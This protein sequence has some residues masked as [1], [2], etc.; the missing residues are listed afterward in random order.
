MAC[1][2]VSKGIL[3]EPIYGKDQ[4]EQNNQQKNVSYSYRFR[5]VI[6]K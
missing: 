3:N 1:P 2:Y 4:T 6:D 5:D